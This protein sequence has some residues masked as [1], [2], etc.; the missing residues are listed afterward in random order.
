M[1]VIVEGDAVAAKSVA[2]ELRKIGLVRIAGYADADVVDTWTA[3]Q[4]RPRQLQLMNVDALDSRR[5]DGGVQI[6]DVRSPDEWAA[7]HLPDAVHIPLAALPDRVGEIDPGTPVVVHCQ[8]GGRSAI[9]ASFL[10]SKG[11]DG[12]ANLE[13]GFEAWRARELPV[14]RDA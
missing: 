2:G 10:K 12:V 7:G 5:K 8:G 6:I 9:A 14:E 3:R 4:T 11:L 13:G 1:Y